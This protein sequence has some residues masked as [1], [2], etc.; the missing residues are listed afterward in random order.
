MKFKVYF[1]NILEFMVL[2]LRVLMLG[3]GFSSYLVNMNYFFKNF[4][5][6][7]RYLVDKL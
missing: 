5:F 1:Y 4:F 3:W 2:R 7:I 6:I